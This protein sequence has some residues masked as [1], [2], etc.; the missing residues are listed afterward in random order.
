MEKAVEEAVLAVDELY[1]KNESVDDDIYMESEEP[2]PNKASIQSNLEYMS[3]DC[4]QFQFEHKKL[5]FSQL[6]PPFVIH[7]VKSECQQFILQDMCI[8]FLYFIVV[9]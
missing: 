3:G 9:E 6:L 4:C 2:D 5:P 7:K 1:S 8:Y